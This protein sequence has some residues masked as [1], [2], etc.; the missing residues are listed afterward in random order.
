MTNP[1]TLSSIVA[2]KVTVEKCV[3]RSSSRRAAGN[4]ENTH[5]SS[6]KLEPPKKLQQKSTKKKVGRAVHFTIDPPSQPQTVMGEEMF[7]G[8]LSMYTGNQRKAC[9]FCRGAVG[10]GECAAETIAAS[11]HQ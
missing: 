11:D 5:G 4:L 2:N 8:L 10:A 9:K 6:L 3:T 7:D 1:Q